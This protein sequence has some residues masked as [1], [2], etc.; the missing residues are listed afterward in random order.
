[1]KVDSS[2]SSTNATK[3]GCTVV[4]I[5]VKMSHDTENLFLPKAEHN[6]DGQGIRR[7]HV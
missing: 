6:E 1:M 2:G 3:S 7:V 5:S 4:A